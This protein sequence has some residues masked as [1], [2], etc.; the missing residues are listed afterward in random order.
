M[1]RECVKATYLQDGYS[2]GRGLTG[3]YRDLTVAEAKRTR[4]TVYAVDRHGCV[5]EVRTNGK[6]KV[7][8]TRTGCIL[9]L[10]Y[11]LRECFDVGADYLE[12]YEPIGQRERIVVRVRQPFPADTPPEIV[13]DYVQE[14]EVQ[15]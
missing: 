10:K 12:D 6:P 5:R 13:S 9:H 3:W 7:W 15:R 14:N 11:G 2:G 4:G 1:G 8:K